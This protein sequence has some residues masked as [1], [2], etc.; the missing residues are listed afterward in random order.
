M[1]CASVFSKPV[2]LPFVVMKVNDQVQITLKCWIA[3]DEG[4]KYNKSSAIPLGIFAQVVENR[5]DG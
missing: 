3:L 1:F 5:L 4:S 2:C